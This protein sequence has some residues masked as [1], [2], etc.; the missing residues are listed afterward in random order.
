MRPRHIGLT[1]PNRRFPASFAPQDGQGLSKRFIFLLNSG[2]LPFGYTRLT[3]CPNLRQAGETSSVQLIRT[4]RR[5]RCQRASNPLSFLA[6]L[7]LWQ[8]VQR[9]ANLLTSSLWSTR[10]QSRSNQPTRVN[11][12]KTFGRV[13]RFKA[14]KPA[15]LAPRATLMATGGAA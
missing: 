2:T 13:S 6:L 10:H 5:N 4:T 1:T 9:K 12:S 11:T 8:H 7:S 15:R 14:L 3:S